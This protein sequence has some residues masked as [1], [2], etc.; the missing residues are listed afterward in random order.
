MIITFSP[1]RKSERTNISSIPCA[2]ETTA[3]A[4]AAVNDERE[5]KSDRT[6][7]IVSEA[8]REKGRTEAEI[9]LNL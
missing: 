5:G 9:N 1:N 2:G 7:A 3:A 6:E 8:D 4:A